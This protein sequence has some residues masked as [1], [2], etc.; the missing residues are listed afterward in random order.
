V[1]GSA[2]WGAV[3]D[4][5]ELPPPDQWLLVEGVVAIVTGVMTILVALHHPFRITLLVALIGTFRG[6]WV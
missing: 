2:V 4:P 5:G 3:E 6:W 1:A